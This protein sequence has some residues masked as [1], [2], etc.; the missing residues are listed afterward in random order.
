M[1]RYAFIV[2]VLSPS[3]GGWVRVGGYHRTEDAAWNYLVAISNGCRVCNGYH[4]LFRY[5]DVSAMGAVYDYVE[6]SVEYTITFT[7]TYPS[8]VQP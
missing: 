6:I 8:Q 7:R 4:V 3:A 2:F 5:D 1:P